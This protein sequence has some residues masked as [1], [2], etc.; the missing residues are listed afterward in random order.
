M[1]T[2]VLRGNWS[3]LA[4]LV[5][6]TVGGVLSTVILIDAEVVRLPALSWAIA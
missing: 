3:P 5:I 6:T 2:V 1:F 4:G